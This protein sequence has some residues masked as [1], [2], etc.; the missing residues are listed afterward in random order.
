MKINVIN[1][2]KNSLP[3]YKSKMAAGMDL[4]ADVS[5]IDER[6]TYNCILNYTVDGDI[7]MI[8][9]CPGGRALIPTGLHM[10]IPEGYMLAIVA[11]SGLGLR[12]GITMANAIGIID[13]RIYF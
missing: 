1:K 12:Q 4:R 9:I 7:N 3:E 8:T 2:S 5:K 13:A 10:S 11:R 6:F